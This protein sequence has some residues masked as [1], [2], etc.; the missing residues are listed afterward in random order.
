MKDLVD[1][2]GDQLRS[3]LVGA[4]V[5]SSDLGLGDGDADMLKEDLLE[6]QQ[7]RDDVPCDG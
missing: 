2:L 1:D 5:G 7:P 4:T 6:D 3:C